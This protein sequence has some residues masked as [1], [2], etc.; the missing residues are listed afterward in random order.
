MYVTRLVTYDARHTTYSALC[1]IYGDRHSTYGPRRSTYGAIRTTYYIR[2]TS[3]YVR[4]RMRDTT[5]GI[6]GTTNYMRCTIDDTIYTTVYDVHCERPCTHTPTY[7]HTLAHAY[8]DMEK[9]ICIHT[10]LICMW[11]HFFYLFHNKHQAAGYR[12]ETILGIK[13]KIWSM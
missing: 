9:Y 10:C 8:T 13:T 5:H 1:T 4:Y 11:P 2:H 6:W 7:N 3:H 12:I